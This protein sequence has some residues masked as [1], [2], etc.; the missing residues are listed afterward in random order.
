M[1]LA[2][3]K[4]NLR[5]LIIK[6]LGKA[7]EKFK[8]I[9]DSESSYIT[10]TILHQ[11]NHSALKKEIISGTIPDARINL[12]RNRIRAGLLDMISDLEEDDVN[13]VAAAENLKPA[14]GF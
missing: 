11:S 14:K 13:M 6:D 3:I 1:T 10:P 2:Q 7:L 4:E 5:S 9:L 8:S 12:T